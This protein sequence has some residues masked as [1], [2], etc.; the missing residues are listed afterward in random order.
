MAREL[1][2][3]GPDND[4][5]WVSSASFPQ[6]GIDY[7]GTEVLQRR[8]HFARAFS[9]SADLDASKIEAYLQDGV[10]KLTIPRPD[11]IAAHCQSSCWT[12]TSSKVSMTRQG[13]K[14][15]TRS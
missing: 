2:P 1:G 8:P 4:L 5:S 14:P 15:A 7:E 9:L 11:G 3:H 12:P 13:T 10:L 6:I